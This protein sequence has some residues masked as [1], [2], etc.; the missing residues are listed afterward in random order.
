MK[1]VDNRSDFQLKKKNPYSFNSELQ[2]GHCISEKIAML[3]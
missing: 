1:N 2:G 3:W